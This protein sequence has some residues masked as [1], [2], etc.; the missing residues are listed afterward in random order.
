MI[1]STRID[2]KIANHL[3]REI[4]F[5]D[6]QYV[7]S[8]Q[9]GVPRMACNDLDVMLCDASSIVLWEWP[10]QKKGKFVVAEQDST[11]PM[12]LRLKVVDKQSLD[13]D[14]KNIIDHDGYLKTDDF[15]KFNEK[16]DFYIDLNSKVRQGPST[17]QMC[18]SGLMDIGDKSMDVV[19]C[20]KCQ[21]WPP[22]KGDFFT[23]E[24]PNNWPSPELLEKVKGLECHVVPV[25]YP[26]SELGGIVWRLSFSIAERALITE[27]YKP[28][29]ECMFALKAIKNKFID[30]SD[31]DKPTPFCS[32]FIKTACL[33]KCET[34]RHTD[35]SLMDLIREV[36]DW[37]ID[38]YQHQCL[39]H[40]FI[41]EH[42]LIGHLEERCDSVK[43][44]LTEIKRD[45]WTKV[46][47]S[48][49]GDETYEWC[50]NLLG[51]EFNINRDDEMWQI[52]R[53]KKKRNQSTTG[54]GTPESPKSYREHNQR[55]LL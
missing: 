47:Y 26:G 11:P 25:G 16:K 22:F 8:S 33:W 44:K 1:S 42:N 37:L 18:K 13:K 10:H 2:Q 30:Y 35:C 12:Y 55:N 31:S 40:Y 28:Y 6:M 45:L 17:V 3:F 27:M 21:S 15:I 54:H 7:G 52:L 49:D 9:E 23:R 53:P 32:Y 24:R 19:F 46:L 51:N 41:R 48:I 39:P 38:C 20:L 43:G 36:L 5:D 34:F 14:F 4:K 50:F 29:A